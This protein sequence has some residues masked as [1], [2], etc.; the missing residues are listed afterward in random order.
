MI[1]ETYK[2]RKLT[3]RKGKGSEWGTVVIT[4]NSEVVSRPTTL[5]LEGALKS[6]R[7]TID[8]VDQSPVDGGR[9]GA[10][11][12]APG[13]FEMCPEGLHPQVIG[14]PCTHPTCAAKRGA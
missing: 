12:Y 10:Y 1:R 14:G 3:A 4:C 7:A 5:D 11:L 6:V 9:W 8:Y 13:T 2:G